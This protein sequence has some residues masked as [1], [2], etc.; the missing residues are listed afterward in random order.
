[1]P[2]PPRPLIPDYEW[3]QRLNRGLGGYRS[4]TTGRTVART[5]IIRQLDKAADAGRDTMRELSR[6][7][8][9][10]SISLPEW[11]RLMAQEIKTVHIYNAA[12]AK[13]GWAQMS[14]ADWGRVGYQVKGQYEYLRNFAEEL[15]NGDQPLN[16]SVPVRASMYGRAGHNTYE[17][18]RRAD[19][20]QRGMGKVRR[21]LTPGENCNGC[22]EEAQKGWVNV[23]ELEPIGSQECRSNCRC[24]D[25]YAMQEAE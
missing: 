19:A 24:W 10:G 22:I 3:D 20:K 13:G 15:A 6:R 11:Q 17:A 2:N 18:M 23:G 1:M 21:H 25:E 5:E 16:G 7:L 12:A 9:D 8:V 4:T 14:Q